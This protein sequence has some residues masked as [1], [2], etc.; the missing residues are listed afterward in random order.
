MSVK[1]VKFQTGMKDI[2]I[3]YFVPVNVENNE[4]V[5]IKTFAGENVIYIFLLSS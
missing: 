4:E 2:Q 5:I 3:P 1:D